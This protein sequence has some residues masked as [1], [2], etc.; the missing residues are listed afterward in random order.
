MTCTT[1]STK[2]FRS[3]RRN[4]TLPFCNSISLP[5]CGEGTAEDGDV[6]K[7]SDVSNETGASVESGKSGHSRRG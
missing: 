3:R 7:T 1:T 5:V 4:I 2:H 6:G